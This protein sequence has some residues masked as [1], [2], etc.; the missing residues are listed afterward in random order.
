MRLPNLRI[1]ELRGKALD[2]LGQLVPRSRENYAEIENAINQTDG[3]KADKA[4]VWQGVVGAFDHDVQ[5]TAS[6]ITTDILDAPPA[7]TAKIVNGITFANT[8]T[9]TNAI[10]IQLTDGVIIHRLHLATIAAWASGMLPYTYVVPYGHSLRVIPNYGGATRLTHCAVN[11]A[12][13]PYG[14]DANG[15]MPDAS[16]TKAKY[17]LAMGAHIGTGIEVVVPAPAHGIKRIVRTIVFDNSGVAAPYTLFQLR[18]VSTAAVYSLELYTVAAGTVEHWSHVNE[19]ALCLNEDTELIITHN[20]D[21]LAFTTS[22]H[23]IDTAS[24]E[25]RL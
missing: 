18:K 12:S 1:P 8:A 10:L 14:P 20:I 9:N 24:A 5:L 16:I 13:V 6:S 11:Y 22:A 25:S 17:G 2:Y 3:E 15:Y 7:L 21:P 4:G 23:Y 19:C